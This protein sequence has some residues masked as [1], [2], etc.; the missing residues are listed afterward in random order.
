MLIEKNN[1]I[2]EESVLANKMNQYFTSI[3]K[4]LNLKKSSRL[5]NLE[6]IINNYHNHISIE[7]I[8]SS[9]NTKSDLFT[10]NLVSSDKIT[11][12]I[13]TLNNKKTSREGDILVNI[14]KDTI[15][16]YLPTLTKIVNSSIEQN[17]SPNEVKLTD[18]L[19]I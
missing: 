6:D 8:K 5:K 15:D 11:R 10:F 9:N 18:V 3:K 14:L 12:E 4:Q 2:L 17:E 1:L 16:T 19:P 7:K 13:L